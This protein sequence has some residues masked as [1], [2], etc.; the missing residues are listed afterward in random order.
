MYQLEQRPE[1]IEPG[2]RIV[3]RQHDDEEGGTVRCCHWDQGRW[4]VETLCGTYVDLSD[5]LMVAELD[6][7][8]QI[9]SSFTTQNLWHENE[10]AR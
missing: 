1:P 7:E 9:L 4:S 2:R 10:C 3:Y 5:I 6:S 8:G